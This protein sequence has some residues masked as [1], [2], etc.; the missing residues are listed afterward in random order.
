VSGKSDLHRSARDSDRADRART[1]SDPMIS[2]FPHEEI[3]DPFRFMLMAVCGW[4]N[5]Q[6]LIAACLTRTRAGKCRM[7]VEIAWIIIL[8]GI[9]GVRCTVAPELATPPVGSGWTVEWGIDRQSKMNRF[10]YRR[11]SMATLGLPEIERSNFRTLR[12]ASSRSTK[13]RSRTCR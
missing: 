11:D 13:F 9:H 4:M 8:T 2:C 3:L 6:Q 7:S 10:L 12:R 5:Q 1:A